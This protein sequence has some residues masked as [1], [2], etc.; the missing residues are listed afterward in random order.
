[1]SPLA[2]PGFSLDEESPDERT[3]VLT[4]RGELDIATAPALGARMRRLLFWRDVERVIVDLSDV[5][6]IDSSGVRTLILSRTHAD[7]L[8]RGLLFVCPDG[9]VLRRVQAYG[10]DEK[11]SFYG[12]MKEAFAV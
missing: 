4:V 5:S 3:R 8:D 9:S 7:S 1:M 2:L 6:F 12:T 11:L 10:L